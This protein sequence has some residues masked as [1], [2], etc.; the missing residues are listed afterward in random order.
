MP[1]P[2]SVS[3]PPTQ[4]IQNPLR[5]SAEILLVRQ[6]A[7]ELRTPLLRSI[8]DFAE[9]EIVIPTGPAQGRFRADR[10]PAMRLLFAELAKDCWKRIFLT[11]PNQDGKSVCM[12]IVVMYRLFECQETVVLG[13]PSLD[14]VRDKWKT[15]FLPIIRASR[16]ADLLP[17]KGA[18]SKEG[19]SVLF[20][21]GNG[22]HLRFMTAGGDDKA[23]A[24]FTSRHLVV[25]ETDGF[26]EIGGESREGDKLAQL[27]A[28]TYSFGASAR[29]FCECTVSTEKGRTWQEY[30]NGTRSRIAL[31][32]PHCHDW[33]TPE[34]EHLVGWQSAANKV[35]A[36][37]A[38]RICCPSCGVQWTNDER[39]LAN[40]AARL[41][42]KGQS[43]DAEGNIVGDM[44]AVD[45]LGFRW[46]VVNSVLSPDRLG[47]VGGM[48]WAA[49][50]A[51]D[52]ET[53]DKNLRQKQW[54]LPAKPTRAD[55]NVLD[56]SRILARA[57]PS[58]GRGVCPEGTQFVT[59]G[60]DVGEYRCHWTGIAWRPGA[61]AHI[62]EY[63]VIDVAQT[64]QSPEQCILSAL[65][66]WRKDVIHAGWAMLSP[67]KP[68][69]ILKPV[70]VFCDA[71]DHQSTILSFVAEPES[72]PTFF[73]CKGFGSTQ[74]RRSSG[75]RQTG[76]KVIA[77]YAGYAALQLPTGE[78]L[79]E[80]ASDEWKSWLNARLRTPLGESGAMTLFAGSAGP[81]DHFSF[82]K[83]LTAETQ[84]EQFSATEGVVRRWIA[85]H[86]NNHWLDSTSYACVAGHAA[87]ARLI[88]AQP[89]PAPSPRPATSPGKT[90][91]PTWMPD[92]P[93]NWTNP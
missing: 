47:E 89:A 69:V 1:P 28:R 13:V 85:K 67:G 87:G 93:T 50:R 43:I 4:P 19:Q 46:T 16:Y 78:G 20:S 15:D 44:P 55:L 75:I 56:S 61:T 54:A 25:T 62:V 42:H 53:A 26:D 27:E 18:G 66:E 22:V 65:R 92:R 10:H 72:G 7:S 31:P 91:R 30:L 45:T 29:E 14:L 12:V 21:F 3:L 86:R 63:G 58:L 59:V 80:I 8:L 84:V 52:E 74:R 49:Q 76:T 36:V 57:V 83:Q 60:L 39:I 35:D 73:A 24:S 51:A 64:G 81:S 41:L 34:R 40:Q 37:A 6:I 33:V 90:D 79:I 38:T 70:V 17:N 11:G 88:E 32:C 5:N 2:S 48:E 9:A 71:G 23:R 77:G 68:A 82:A